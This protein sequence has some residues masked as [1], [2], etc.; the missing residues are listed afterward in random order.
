MFQVLSKG[1]DIFSFLE[2]SLRL[3]RG[4]YPKEDSRVRFPTWKRGWLEYG[5]TAGHGCVGCRLPSSQR[6]LAVRVPGW[7]S[8]HEFPCLTACPSTCWRVYFEPSKS[9]APLPLLSV[10]FQGRLTFRDVAGHFTQEER[11]AVPW[12]ESP[13]WETDLAG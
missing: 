12:A 8:F 7:G 9:F 1:R 2:D 5:V 11:Q 6:P 3:G 13:V 4:T 10:L